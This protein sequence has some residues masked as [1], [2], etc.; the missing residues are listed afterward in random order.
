MIDL[1]IS[2]WVE[3]ISVLVLIGILNT[4]LFK[5]I[6]R[7]LEERR[8]KMDSIQGEVERL[9]RNAEQILASF[10]KKLAEARKAGQAERE[11]LK[12]EAR[13]I[14]HEL[15]ESSIK[16][17]D[18]RKQRLVADLSV[19]IDNAKKELLAKSDMFAAEIAQKLLGRAI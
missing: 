13:K 17:A 11:R 1:D 6:R 5:P 4:M 7:M 10:N 9:T 15:L 12:A 2:L 8:A 14:E 3:V 18:E 19:Q 16:E